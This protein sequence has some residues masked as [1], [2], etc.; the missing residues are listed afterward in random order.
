MS[1]EIQLSPEERYEKLST[2]RLL[3]GFYI[4]N[5]LFEMQTYLMFLHRGG[6]PLPTSFKQWQERARYLKIKD[7]QPSYRGYQDD[8]LVGLMVYVKHH[9]YM[10]LNELYK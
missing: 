10:M 4:P 9:W 7:L 3:T 6:F 2:T 8:A 1:E 5:R